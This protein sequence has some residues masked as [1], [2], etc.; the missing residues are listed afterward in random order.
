MSLLPVARAFACLQILLALLWMTGSTF[1]QDRYFD[2]FRASESRAADPIASPSAIPPSGNA[3]NNAQG[4]S[5]DSVPNIVADVQIVGNNRVPSDQVLAKLRTR[6]NRAYDRDLVQADTR[7]IMQMRYFQN[8]KTYTKPTPDGIV[9]TFEVEER[10]FI[11]KVEIIGNRYLTDRALLKQIDLKK[12]MPLDIYAVKM[13]KQK[14][15][16]YYQDKGYSRSEVTIVEGDKLGDQNVIFLINEDEP[17]KIKSIHVEGNSLVNEAR[18][19]TFLKSKPSLLHLFG[20]KFSRAK[21]DQDRQILESYYHS[22]GYFNVRI[23][24]EVIPD[25]HSSWLKLLFV[26][27]EGPRSKVRNINFVGQEKYTEADLAQLTELRPNEFFNAVQMQADETS[28]RDL[29][30]GQGHIAADVNAEVIF[31]EKPDVV[32]LVYRIEE[33]P[34]YRVGRINVQIEGDHGITKKQVVLNRIDLKPGDVVDMRKI[35][36][37]ERRLG[38]S[39]LFTAQ[40]SPGPRL[41]VKPRDES[42]LM[43]DADMGGETRWQSPDGEEIVWL[44]IT[45][46][47]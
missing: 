2:A 35:R 43:A 41:V 7:E 33:G 32:D 24:A 19:K 11:G 39:Q 1:G 25:D 34:Q 36:D 10:P 5:A 16:S 14:L 45:I 38:A 42:L 26:I 13:A 37:S 44:D 6:A 40:G 18:L 15:E 4:L 3:V 9:V 22:L 23:G 20:G 17:Q 12:D 30:G 28:L 27:D 29:Y 31:S 46:Y 21:V 8:V 47:P